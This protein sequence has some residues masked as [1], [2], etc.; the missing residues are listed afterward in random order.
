MVKLDSGEFA[1]DCGSL[2]VPENLA[3]PESRLMG[4]YKYPF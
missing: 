4:M 2:I 3:N 1:A